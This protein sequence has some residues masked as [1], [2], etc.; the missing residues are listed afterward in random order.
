MR[1]LCVH[2]ACCVSCA[3][4]L[5]ACRALAII[6][7]ILQIVGLVFVLLLLLWVIC[8]WICCDTKDD[9]CERILLYATPIIWII[10]GLICYRQVYKLVCEN[11]LSL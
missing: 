7:L 8:R 1:V 11:K 6:S 10:T 9:M 2:V 4:W 5:V 3:A